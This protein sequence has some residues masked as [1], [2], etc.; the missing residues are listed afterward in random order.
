MT[1]AE[2]LQFLLFA[3]AIAANVAVAFYV[4]PMWRQRRLRFFAIL[5]CSALL[6]I[7]VAL[8]DRF[9]NHTPMSVEQY[10]WLWCA[11]VFLNIVDLVLY[12]VGVILMIRHFQNTTAPPPPPSQDQ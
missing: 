1:L 2:A 7:F 10:Y 6:G 3:V 8:A 9:L 11:T 12:A 4:M 5:G